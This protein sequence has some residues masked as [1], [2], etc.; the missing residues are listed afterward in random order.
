MEEVSEADVPQEML[1]V[2]SV[3]FTLCLVVEAIR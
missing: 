3:V 2:E 1:E